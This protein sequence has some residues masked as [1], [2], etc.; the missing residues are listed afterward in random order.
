MAV[1]IVMRIRWSRQQIIGVTELGTG[2]GKGKEKKET[3]PLPL[4]VP[5]KV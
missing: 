3:I 2:K 1:V 4:P 5:S